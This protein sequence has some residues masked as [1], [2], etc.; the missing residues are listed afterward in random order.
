MRNFEAF[1]RSIFSRRTIVWG[2]KP[3]IGG[4]S[5]N[6]LALVT[7]SLRPVCPITLISAPASIF[8]P[9]DSTDHSAPLIRTVPAALKSVHRPAF[10]TDDIF[11]S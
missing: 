9:S 3:R 4:C 7:F 10:Q 11:K 1:A 8:S 2:L 6:L 5:F